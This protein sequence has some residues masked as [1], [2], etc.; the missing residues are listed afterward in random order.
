MVFLLILE[1]ESGARNIYAW[2]DDIWIDNS[3]NNETDWSKCRITHLINNGKECYSKACL[4]V[5][6]DDKKCLYLG[7]WQHSRH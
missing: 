5:D 2:C 4:T 1:N 3:T 7:K 6:K